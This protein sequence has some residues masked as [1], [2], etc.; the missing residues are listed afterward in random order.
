[1]TREGFSLTRLQIKAV[2]ECARR[3]LAVCIARGLE[4]MDPPAATTACLRGLG[5]NEGF[6]KRLWARLP[7]ET[8][9]RV[10]KGPGVEID[11][12][13]RHDKGPV[14][15]AEG[16]TPVDLLECRRVGGEKATVSNRLYIYFEGDIEGNVVRI[17]VLRLL[18]L[19]HRIGFDSL[20]LVDA[21]LEAVEGRDCERIVSKLGEAVER[22]RGLLLALSPMM[23][24]SIP[25]LVARSP[26]L[27]EALMKCR[28]G[29]G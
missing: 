9:L 20:G 13:L 19:A 21:V 23:P 6:V 29:G 15:H 28:L 10:Y 4:C 1:M 3:V 16:R 11:L 7:P 8:R 27:R 2:A 25:Q 14:C 17:N 12:V 26:L 5:Y 24:A 22:F 18:V